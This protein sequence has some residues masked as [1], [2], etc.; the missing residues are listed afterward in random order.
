M[1]DRKTNVPVC[2]FFG[3][4]SASMAAKVTLTE[5]WRGWVGP[6]VFG[7]LAVMAFYAVMGKEAKR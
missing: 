1:A 4:Y 6:L 7:M 5:G 2:F 3:V